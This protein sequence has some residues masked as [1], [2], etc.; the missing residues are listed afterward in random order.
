M[1]LGIY[2]GLLKDIDHKVDLGGEA[3]A[4]DLVEGE[5]G[6]NRLLGGETCF[7]RSRVR[8]AGTDN[9]VGIDRGVRR[10]GLETG[11]EARAD[12]FAFAA[13][14]ELDELSLFEFWD[15]CWNCRDF[16]GSGQTGYGGY[17][18][19]DLEAELGAWRQVVVISTSWVSSLSLGERKKCGGAHDQLEE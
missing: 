9:F 15:A 13:D 2:P 18:R 16:G 1:K 6:V 12:Q 19:T 11:R 10:G 8:E 14:S 7:D 4:A 5:L 17:H 3:G